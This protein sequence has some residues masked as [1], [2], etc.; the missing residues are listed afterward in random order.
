MDPVQI[1]SSPVY[2][3]LPIERFDLELLPKEARIIGSEK[4]KD[5]VIAHFV[6]EYV[7]KNLTAIV[8]VDSEEIVVCTLPNDQEPLDFVLSMLQSGRIQEAVP[9]L[10][11]MDKGSPNNS[12]VLYNLG[13]AYSELGQFDEAIIR[14]KRAVK[15]EP[16]HAHAWTA[17]GVAYQRSGKRDLAIEPLEMAVKADPTDGYA[18]RNLGAVLLS[19]GKAQD[20]L[21]HFREARKALPHDPQTTYGLAAALEEVGGEENIQE[22]DELYIVVVERFPASP[23]A[24]QARQART[25][26]SHQ[27]M[28]ETTNG[29]IRPDVVMYIAG[30]LDTFQKVGTAKRQQI[31]L[32]IALKGQSGLD[33]NDPEQKYTLK[34]LPGSFSGM[35]LVSIMYAAFKQ[36]DPSMDSG[37]DLQ[38]EY[39]AALALSKN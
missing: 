19:G 20:A 29:A 11:A 7:G 36:I 28:R 10:E 21:L 13:L 22:A 24:E 35:H 34:T 23:V 15:V 9:Y 1:M 32:E 6:N 18:R 33:I 16:T 3:K 38:V 39:D 17:I 26:L 37:V 14:L 25:R 12:Q 30:A 4:F 31:A 2:F 5:A 27:S 8:T